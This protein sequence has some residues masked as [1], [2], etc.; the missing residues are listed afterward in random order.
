MPAS[1]YQHTTWH[2][3]SSASHHTLGST[4]CEGAQPAAR[5]AVCVQDFIHFSWSKTANKQ[6]T[7]LLILA[8][9][10][11]GG[12]IWKQSVMGCSCIQERFWQ[13]RREEL[14]GKQSERLKIL[15]AE[16]APGST[17]C[18]VKGR[19]RW[20]FTTLRLCPRDIFHK[21]LRFY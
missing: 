8:V 7:S 17:F 3:T 11:P 19:G 6:K 15:W 12:V 16:M 1:L 4:S 14:F 9:C 18:W 20:G 10:C 13:S 21:I 2:N 5:Q